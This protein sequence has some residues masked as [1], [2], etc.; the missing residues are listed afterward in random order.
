LDRQIFDRHRTGIDKQP[1]L[2]IPAVKR[3]PLTDDVE[4]DA[5]LQIDCGQLIEGRARQRNV[6][7]DVDLIDTRTRLGGGLRDDIVQISHIQD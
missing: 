5:R 2:H 7:T 6:G 3:V 1:T 4:R